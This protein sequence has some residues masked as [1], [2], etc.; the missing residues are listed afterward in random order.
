LFSWERHLMLF[1]ILGQAINPL[2]W[3][4][5]LTKDMQTK[6]RLCWSSVTAQSIVQ[7]IV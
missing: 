4:P 1:P 2:W 3:W 7:H 5:S 6:Q